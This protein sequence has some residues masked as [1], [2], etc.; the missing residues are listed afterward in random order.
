MPDE[1]GPTAR[2]TLAFLPPR[3]GDEVVGGSEAVMREAAEGLARRGW[4]VEILT[5]CARDHYTWRNEYPPGVSRV[6]GLTLRRFPAVAPAVDERDLFGRRIQRNLPLSLDDQCRWI[7]ASMRAPDLFGY[8]L[9]NVDRYRAVVLSP[10]LSWISV[11]CVEVVPQRTILMP[12]VHDESYA[13]LELFRSLLAKPAHLWF[14]SEPEHQLA[15]RLAPLGEHT[16]TGAGVDVPDSYDPEGFRRRYRLERPYVLYAG[17]RER[18]KGWDALMAAYEL[19]VDAYGV[20][21]DLV[22]IGAGKPIIPPSLSRRVHDLGFLPPADRDSAFAA[23]EAYL[24]PSA[25]E[26]FSRS[27]MEAWLARTPV[28]ATAKGAV[29]RWHCERSQGGLI[30]EDDLEFAQCLLAVTQAPE[31]VRELA[32]KGRAYVLEHYPWSRV[33]D[34]MEA[35]LAALP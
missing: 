26:S 12:C 17:R 10:Y 35:T 8:L 14:L 13:Y 5:T 29:V 11:A 32:A 34:R 2:G 1:A 4:D 22:T 9:R 33:L 28:I 19:A 31:A 15:Q 27:L 25:N 16:V 20:D 18:E 24:Q 23:A 30:Y 7:N 21:L 3:F 6:G